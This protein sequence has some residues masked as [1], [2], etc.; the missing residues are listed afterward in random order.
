MQTVTIASAQSQGIESARDQA[1]TKARDTL[2]E[3]VVLSWR[4]DAKDT[5]APEIPGAVTPERWKE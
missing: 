1:V 4:D 5:I 3:P 2:K